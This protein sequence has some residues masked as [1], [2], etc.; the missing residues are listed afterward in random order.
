MG[1]GKASVAVESTLE[2]D[3]ALLRRFDPEVASLEEQPVR[4]TYHADGGAKRHYIPD[5]LV[6]FRETSRP[7]QLVEVKYS[8][9]PKLVAGALE[10]KFAAARGF[11]A[12]RGW[13]FALAT[14]KEI[15]T[16]RLENATFLLPFRD[17]QPNPAI[18]ER[19]IE[20]V[21]DGP[22]ITVQALADSVAEPG[23]DRARVLP[24]LWTLVA[25]FELATDLD[26]PITM[27]TVLQLP[28]RGTA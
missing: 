21:A 13:V 17:R 19:I 10:A 28:G 14:E 12:E 16:P 22:P 9:D 11:A 23:S 2:R 7:P 20:A 15:R 1:P 27:Q 4:I 25:R 26:R 18:R 5:F 8:T 6:S 3:F 24:C